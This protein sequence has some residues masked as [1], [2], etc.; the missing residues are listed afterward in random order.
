MGLRL[1]RAIGITF[2]FTGVVLSAAPDPSWIVITP[3]ES[4]QSLVNLYPTGTT[5]YLKAGIHYK[6][7]VVPKSGNRF[8]GEAGAVMDGQ[9]VTPYAFETLKSLPTG[10][11]IQGLEIRNYVPPYSYQGAIQGDNGA[12]WV[13]SD[14]RIHDN[15]IAGVRPGKNTQVL[16][17]KLYRNAYNGIACHKCDGV[18]IQDNEIY[19]N[20]PTQVRTHGE[21][22][23]KLLGAKGITIRRNNVHD[24]FGIGIW[25]DTNLPTVLI[26]NNTVTN[27]SRGGIWHEVSYAAIIRYNT[28]TGNGTPSVAITGW[29]D[30]AGIQ[31]SNSPNVQVYG[32]TVTNNANG[33]TVMQASGYPATGEYGAHTV[34]NLFVHDNVVRMPTGRSGMDANNGDMSIYT[35]RNNHF[36]HNTYYLG[37]SSNPF[38]W[39]ELVMSPAQWQSYGNDE[40]GT[41]YK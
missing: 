39:N 27:N 20:N 3:G 24:N 38:A 19:S 4:I 14:N 17:N 8:I 26:E 12:N 2:L 21:G 31:V 22:G 30:R 33:I 18:L 29:I 11:T 37:T 36:E 7:R 10:V 25:S 9:K 32:N 6:Q 16:R 34:Q 41:I 1:T 28:A 35:S 40:T 5:F 15:G 23:M 13:I